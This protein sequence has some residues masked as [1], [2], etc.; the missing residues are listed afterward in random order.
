MTQPGSD[1]PVPLG[2][3]IVVVLAG[4]YLLWRLVEGIG[5]LLARI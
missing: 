2:F 1:E 4:L 3:K 5:W